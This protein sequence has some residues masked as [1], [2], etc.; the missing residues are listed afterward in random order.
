MSAETDSYFS[1]KFSPLLIVKSSAQPERT[2][3][4]K[5][6]S[7][8]I[9]APQMIYPKNLSGNING[10]LMLVSNVLK[11]ITLINYFTYKSS[12]SE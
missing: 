11:T 10:S 9:R 2:P 12:Y 5:P 1:I 8:L 4:S 7:T 6:Y 3:L